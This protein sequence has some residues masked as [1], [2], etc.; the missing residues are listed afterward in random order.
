[1]RIHRGSNTKQRETV[2]RREACD[3]AHTLDA[4]SAAQ[5]YLQMEQ[6]SQAALILRRSN[7]SRKGGS[8]QHED[9]DVF[10]GE[11][12]VGRIYRIVTDMPASE[13]FWGVSFKVTKRKSYGHAASIEEAKAA[14]RAEYE[15]WKG[16]QNRWGASVGSRV[17]GV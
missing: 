14:F 17:R 7:V 16:T 10:D 15:A 3:K 4:T 12:E 8:W 5:D 2:K 1:M 6:E 11:R 13:W 9:Y